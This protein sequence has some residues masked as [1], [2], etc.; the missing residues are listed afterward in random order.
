AMSVL[1][2]AEYV[3]QNNLE[4]Q[5]GDDLIYVV[6]CYIKSVE[7]YTFEKVRGICPNVTIGVSI[8]GRG[9]QDVLVKSDEFRDNATLGN[10][11]I[12]I[13]NNRNLFF[14]NGNMAGRIINDMTNW[15]RNERNS[16]FHRDVVADSDTAFRIR[17]NTLQLIKDMINNFR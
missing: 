7:I 6:C 17:R 4:N 14:R 9:K 15:L 12:L 1:Q 10:C 13:R 16:H 2:T 3:W 5:Q 11:F 8:S